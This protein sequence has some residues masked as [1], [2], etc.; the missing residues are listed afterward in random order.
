MKEDRIMNI[1]NVIVGQR[2]KTLRLELG[3]SME[4]FGKRFNTSKGTVNNWE[5]GRNLPNKQNLAKLAKLAEV[6]V[7]D[8]TFSIPQ[9]NKDYILSEVIKTQ[10]LDRDEE[11]YVKEKISNI[12]LSPEFD[13]N[14][15]T[16]EARIGVLKDSYK[17]KR[18]IETHT[19]TEVLNYI[20]TNLNKDIMGMLI[21]LGD[22]LWEHDLQKKIKTD[23]E[24]NKFTR[25]MLDINRYKKLLLAQF[26]IIEKKTPEIKR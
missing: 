16:L 21:F 4:E 18:F 12:T 9:N 6:S 5:K 1:E 10:F 25:L 2:I 19:V 7:E 15:I 24:Q 13:N 23:E 3:E 20:S 14:S 22:A 11:K 17:I 26:K 8:F